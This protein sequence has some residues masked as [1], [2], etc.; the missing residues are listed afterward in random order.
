[1]KDKPPPQKASLLPNYNF[2][3]ES[4]ETQELHQ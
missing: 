1:M 3:P 4:M 2:T